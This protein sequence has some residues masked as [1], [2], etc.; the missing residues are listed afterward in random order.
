MIK[1]RNVQFTSVE[2]S[3]NF[4]KLKEKY[5]QVE[6]ASDYRSAAYIVALPDVFNLVGDINQLEWLFSWCYEFKTV[7]VEESDDWDYSRNGTYYRRDFKE[8]DE[9]GNMV[10]GGSRFAGLS[11]GGRRLTLAA[12]N[13]FNGAKGF[14]LED[15]LCSWDD[16]LFEVFLNACLLRKGGRIG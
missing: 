5:P 3:T 1:G 10:V 7:T 2:H 13:L 6:N 16:R 8:L 11:G 14:D 12:M 4:Q 15:G 9:Q